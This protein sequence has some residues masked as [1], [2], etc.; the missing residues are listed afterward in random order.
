MY[1][2]K[3]KSTKRN[4]G[5]SG[6]MGL[7]KEQVQFALDIAKLI[8]YAQ[9]IGFELTFGEAYR[10]PYQ[11]KEYL[12]TGRSK[13][14]KSQ[15]LKRLAVDF[16]LFIDGNLSWEYRDFAFLG[17]Y[18]ESLSPKNKWGGHFRNFKDFP[19]FQRTE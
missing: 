16:N 3:R 19:H 9:E 10:T 12:R 13:T 2:C 15:H 1:G 18:W 14:M 7:V 17:E 4:Y 8:N 11:Q 6:I 5:E